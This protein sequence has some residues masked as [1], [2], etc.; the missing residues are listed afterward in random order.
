MMAKV[1]KEIERILRGA[2]VEGDIELSVPPN[3]EMGDAAFA[4]FGLAKIKKN[5]PAETAKELHSVIRLKTTKLIEKIEF[6]GPYVNFFLHTGSLADL[7]IRSIDKKPA[8]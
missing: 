1:R 6:H 4:C 3:P 2:G 8:S 5:N 7:V